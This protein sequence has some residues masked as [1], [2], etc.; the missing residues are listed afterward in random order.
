MKRD[1][2]VCS[3]DLLGEKKGGGRFTGGKP[4]VKL[5]TKKIQQSKQYKKNPIK[6]KTEESKHVT[7][8]KQTLWLVI[9]L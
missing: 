9:L 6:I 8:K 4:I 7:T 1:P 5:V 3:H 2:R